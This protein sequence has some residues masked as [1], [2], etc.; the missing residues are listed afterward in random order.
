M[1]VTITGLDLSVLYSSGAASSGVAYGNPILALA[2]AEQNQPKKIAAEAKTP[3]VQRDLAAFRKAVAGAKDVKSLLANP[4]VQR[5]LLTVNGLADQIG[6]TALATKALLSKPSDPKSLANVLPNVAWKAAAKTYGFA[7]KGL[8]ILRDPK[9]LDT[10]ASA[11]AEI[12]WR[13]SLDATTPGLSDALTFRDQAASVTKA[14]DILG[15][16]ILRRVVTTTLGIP[17]E[18]AYQTLNA[19]ETAITSKLDIKQLKSKNFVEN[20][21][22]RYLVAAASSAAQATSSAQQQ[23]S[24]TFGLL[25]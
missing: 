13:K 9:V 12:S 24:Q 14:D 8:T 1:S 22:K 20:F 23:A 16:P 5:V 18:I 2:Q 3:E 7:D 6:F 21:V 25:L 4:T 19:Q 11:Y 10:V 15:N 17:L